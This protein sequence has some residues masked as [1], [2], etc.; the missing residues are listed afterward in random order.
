[1]E[2]QENI[3]FKI[4]KG[5]LLLGIA[6]IVLMLPFPFV[7]LKL[8]FE[9]G[10]EPIGRVIIFLVGGGFI[11]LPVYGGIEAIRTYFKTSHVMHK[12]LAKYG[13][14][15]LISNIRNSTVLSYKNVTFGGCKVYFTDKFVIDCT[16]AIID[17]NEISFMYK[18]VRRVNGAVFS[19]ICFEL[20]DGSQW[21][22]CQNIKDEEI[23]NYM[24]LCYQ[25]NPKIMFGYTKENIAK[26][27][28]RVK[29]YKSGKTDIC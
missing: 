23:T 7:F 12:K 26:H 1:M 4:G 11:F 20:L 28:E 5:I 17:Y 15:N 27:K 18:H 25:H 24:Q 6:L 21:L 14:E 29:Q 19:Y 9:P 10:I 16:T 2:N 13:E 22:L 8:F 3:K